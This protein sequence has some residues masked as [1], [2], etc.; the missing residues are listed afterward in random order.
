MILILGRKVSGARPE[1]LCPAGSISMGT[2]P[3]TK[4]RS[5]NRGGRR[6]RNK[7]TGRAC[8]APG[9]FRAVRPHTPNC[10]PAAHV[11]SLLP[12]RLAAQAMVR[13]RGR[14][15]PYSFLRRGSAG[16]FRLTATTALPLGLW[17]HQT[18]LVTVR[19]A[20]RPCCW[21]ARNGG[22]PEHVGY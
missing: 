17:T 3:H 20:L 18:G 14:K 8:G 4:R 16:L 9:T 5:Q 19:L 10:S 2:R 6:R 22:R 13:V 15:P 11:D 1:C 12:K 21:E 7:L